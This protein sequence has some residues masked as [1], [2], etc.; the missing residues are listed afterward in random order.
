MADWLEQLVAVADWLEQR[1]TTF[2]DQGPQC[3]IFSALEDRRQNYDLNFRESS[4]KRISL[5]L[6][7]VGDGSQLIKASW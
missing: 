4:K 3:I 7:Q 6:E 1:Y 5:S 2:L